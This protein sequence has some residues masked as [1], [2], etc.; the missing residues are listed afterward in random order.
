MP[1]PFTSPVIGQPGPDKGT[2][3]PLE[4]GLQCLAGPEQNCDPVSAGHPQVAGLPS[5]LKSADAA[6][7]PLPVTGIHKP[8]TNFPLPQLSNTGDSAV[9]S[10]NNVIETRFA[11]SKLSQH[12][13]LR[14]PH[15]V[16]YRIAGFR[17]E[18]RQ[19]QTK[20]N[21]A[22]PADK[23]GNPVT[24]YIANGHGEAGKRHLE[25][26][27]EASF[28]V[29]DI[30]AGA[31]RLRSARHDNIGVAGARDVAHCQKSRLVVPS[32]IGC[33]KVPLPLPKST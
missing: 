10:R 17:R 13:A 26:R 14:C 32:T 5:P 31:C 30:D 25:R 16:R 4:Y 12:H 8:S 15:G 19:P 18:F 6:Q 3:K 21:A 29:V 28:A 7:L 24:I 11:F 33:L 20:G 1:S 9:Q 22:R 27:R 2:V 23:I